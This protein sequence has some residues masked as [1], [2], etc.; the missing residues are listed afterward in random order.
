MERSK[1][2]KT[3]VKYLIRQT[4]I[5]C[6]SCKNSYKVIFSNNINYKTCSTSCLLKY[7]LKCNIKK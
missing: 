1:N 7:N 6:P 4:V 2:I 3:P 5:I